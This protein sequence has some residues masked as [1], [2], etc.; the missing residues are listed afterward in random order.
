MY[1]LSLNF[2]V[3]KALIFNDIFY[4]VDDSSGFIGKRYVRTDVIVI[5]YG[6]IIDFDLLN[7]LYIVILRERDSM[8]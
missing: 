6:V 5:F 2:F 1:I 7:V 3:V 4:R 8:K